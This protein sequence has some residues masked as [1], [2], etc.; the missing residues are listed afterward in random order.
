MYILRLALCRRGKGNHGLMYKCFSS[1]DI[2]KSIFASRLL[3][4]VKSIFDV[5]VRTP[6]KDTESASDSVGVDGVEAAYMLGKAW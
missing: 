3:R 6:L 4:G 2:D 5:I 1:S